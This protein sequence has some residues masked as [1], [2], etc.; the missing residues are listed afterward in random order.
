MNGLAPIRELGQLRIGAEQILAAPESEMGPRLRARR[1]LRDGARRYHLLGHGLRR[2][3]GV[4]PC[5]IQ[6]NSPNLK[7]PHRGPLPTPPGVVPMQQTYLALRARRAGL[8]G[9]PGELATLPV[10][11]MVTHSQYPDLRIWQ[12]SAPL[13]CGEHARASARARGG[14]PGTL[15]PARGSA[16]AG[17]GRSARMPAVRGTLARWAA[18]LAGSARLWAGL[19]G[20]AQGRTGPRPYGPM[21][22]WGWGGAPSAYGLGASGQGA[23]S[24]AHAGPPRAWRGG[25]WGVVGGPGLWA[26]QGLAGALFRPSGGGLGFRAL[27]CPGPRTVRPRVPGLCGGMP[28]CGDAGT[29]TDGA[30]RSCWR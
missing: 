27:A 11:P 2:W 12:S 24:R 21:G 18:W 16:W 23:P 10:R 25:I 7:A 30:V 9:G 20:L 22:G 3:R 13:R 5:P 19:P 1:R 17:S 15:G 14:R 6:A 26:A 8:P 28:S 29:R 4:A